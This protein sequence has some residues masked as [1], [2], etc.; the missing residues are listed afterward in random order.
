MRRIDSWRRPGDCKPA[1]LQAAFEG[2][3]QTMKTADSWL[4]WHRRRKPDP[5][6]N[7]RGFTLIELLVVIAIIGILAAILLPA[8]AAAKNRARQIACINNMRQIAL[9]TTVYLGDDHGKLYPGLVPWG[10]PAW[11]AWPTDRSKFIITGSNGSQSALWWPDILRLGGY[12]QEGKVF[13]CPSIKHVANAGQTGS[14][15]TNNMLGIGL[16]TDQFWPPFSAWDHYPLLHESQ[17]RIPSKSVMFADSG[18]VTT[19]TKDLLNADLWVEDGQYNTA[20]HDAG[21]GCCFFRVPTDP[22]FKTGDGRSVPRHDGRVNV[23]CPD[24]HAA[25]IRNSSIGYQH[26]AKYPGVLWV[27]YPGCP[28]GG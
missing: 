25:S 23:A 4:V 14:S 15:S 8:L 17:F 20:L 13:D 1:R 19:A 27:R 28:G 11:P 18:A 3:L 9:A 12:I 24:G 6:R 26:P 21:Y 7:H 10:S 2:V 5:Y 16:N 22:L